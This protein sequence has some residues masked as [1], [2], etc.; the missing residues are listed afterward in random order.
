MEKLLS[1]MEK[2]VSYAVENDVPVMFVTEDTTRSKPK[3]SNSSIN[4]QWNWVLAVC[5][6]DT[7]G[8]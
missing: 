5:V 2:E 6:C 3:M 8:S 7:C 1:T 4:E